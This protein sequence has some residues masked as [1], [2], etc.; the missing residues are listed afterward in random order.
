[1]YTKELSLKKYIWLS[2]SRIKEII[3]KNFSIKK[4]KLTNFKRHVFSR[5]APRQPAKLIMKTIPPITITAIDTLT[6]NSKALLT[7]GRPL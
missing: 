3:M 5:K 1:M 4:I 6:N 2:T 7:S